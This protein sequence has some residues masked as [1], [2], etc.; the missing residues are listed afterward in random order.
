[1]QAR[2]R[3]KDQTP[4]QLNA[5]NLTIVDTALQQVRRL[6]LALRPSMLDDLGLAPALRWMAEQVAARSGVVVCFQSDESTASERLHPQLESACFRIAQ[7]ALTNI[8][9]HAQAKQAHI[10]LALD[11][12]TIT[13][14]VR[15][16]GRGFDTATLQTGAPGGDR[17]G[18]LGMQERAA[19]LGGRLTI[20]SQAGQGCTVRLHCPL[21]ITG[22]GP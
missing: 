11:A 6:A 20:A 19:L 3:F 14:E 8:A 15:D 1:M 5:E 22:S 18:L 9:R 7:E 13:L 10:A 16:D 12:S 17:L 2:H 4:E 21:E